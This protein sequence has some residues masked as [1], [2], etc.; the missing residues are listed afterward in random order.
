MTSGFLAC[1]GKMLAGGLVVVLAACSSMGP[2][3]TAPLVAQPEAD[4]GAVAEGALSIGVV[5][6]EEPGNRSGGVADATQKAAMLAA[7]ALASSNVSLT[8]LPEKGGRTTSLAGQF[9]QARVKAVL[10]G[11]DAR[12]MT[13]LTRAMQTSEAPTLSMAPVTDTKL[14]LYSA[15]LAPRDEARTL[16]AEAKRLGMTR[17]GLATTAATDSTSLAQVIAAIA[18]EEGVATHLIDGG[19]AAAFAKSLAAARASGAID[20]VVFVMDAQRAA[21]L[22]TSGD[23]GGASIIG[24]AGW[25]M[26]EPLPQA[27]KGGWYPSLPRA[28]LGK[29][30]ERFRAAH[31]GETPTLASAVIYD[32]VVM[33]A[34]LDKLAGENA[35]SAS[36]LQNDLGF[37]GFTGPFGFG[38]AGLI[39]SRQYEIV[40][41]H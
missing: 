27:L 3:G 17:L 20:G 31:G 8:I 9:A 32:L 40:S 38:A 6:F 1:A 16:I 4:V 29:F 2:V 36:S 28:A 10:G 35:F 24:N 37:T 12:G 39:H 11:S 23:L 30:I 22:V 13:D 25:A 18:A 5:T 7:Q 33:A 26:A 34:A 14:R 21:A 41:V 19:D 15:A